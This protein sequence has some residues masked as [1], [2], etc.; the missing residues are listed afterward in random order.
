MFKYKQFNHDINKLLINSKYFLH[1][2]ILILL[3]SNFYYEFLKKLNQIYLNKNQ[4]KVENS[5]T[6]IIKINYFHHLMLIKS[7]HPHQE[8]EKV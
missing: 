1:S 8:I 7:I 2:N 4:F 6:K 3:R 5:I